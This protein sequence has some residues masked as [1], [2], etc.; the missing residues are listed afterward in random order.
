MG[1]GFEVFFETSTLRVFPL[2]VYLRTILPENAS[3]F[4]EVPKAMRAVRKKSNI[5]LDGE[6]H[7]EHKGVKP[8]QTW[9]VE[10]V[11]IV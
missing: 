11:H 8:S 1:E 5:A 10:T 4:G 9:E 7:P 3:E 2:I 6:K